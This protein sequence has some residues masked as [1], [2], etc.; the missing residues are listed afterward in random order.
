MENFDGFLIGL[1]PELKTNGCPINR[2]GTISATIQSNVD[3]NRS[4]CD[5]LA[6]WHC[7][8]DI[9]TASNVAATSS[10]L[11]AAVMIKGNQGSQRSQM[12]QGIQGSQMSQESQISV[13]DATNKL[14]KPAQ[15]MPRS[16]G[17]IKQEH[18][19]NTSEYE[20]NSTNAPLHLVANKSS[21]M[22]N[23]QRRMTLGGPMVSIPKNIIFNAPSNATTEANVTALN[24][25]QTSD[26]HIAKLTP[27]RIYNRRKTVA[28]REMS[29]KNEKQTTGQLAPSNQLN[30]PLPAARVNRSGTR[31]QCE[32]CF[33]STDVKANYNRHLLTHTGEKPFKCKFCDKGFTQKGNAVAHM[34]KYHYELFSNPLNWN[35]P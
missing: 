1:P 11:S 3:P 21:S 32:L 14:T 31:F 13:A 33:Y 28:G 30:I 35:L 24:P 10:I 9:G 22:K 6:E 15:I 2:C 18:Q 12:S 7:P 5:R 29:L 27:K 8:H 19:T 20:L 23:R 34:K 17:V 16:K 25:Q 26:V 4:Q